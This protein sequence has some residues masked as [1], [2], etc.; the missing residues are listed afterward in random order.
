MRNVL[1]PALAALLVS[2]SLGRSAESW[3]GFRGPNAAGV[4]QTARPPFKFGPGETVL[5]KS[6]LPG[7]PS[8]PCIWGDRIFLT[9]FAAGK[10]EV[11]C[12]DRRD[13][14]QLWSR[15]VPTKKLEEFHQTEGSPAASTPAT[16][17]SRV[18]SYFGSCGLVCHDFAGKELWRHDLPPALT[19]GNFGSG[20][21]PIIAGELVLLNRD[22]TTG[23]SLLAVRLKDGQK[24][25]ETTRA[26]APTSYSTPVLHRHDG[27]EEVLVAGSLALKGYDPKT[28]LERWAVRGLPSY[29]CTTPVLG[30]GLIFFAGWSPGKADSPW[31][32]W[33]STLSKLDKNS[34]GVITLDEFTE[35]S[36]AAWFKSQDLN[37]NGQL[38][39]EDW[40]TIGGL[41]KRGNNVLLAV[42]PGGHGDVSTTHVAWK[43]ERG[44]PYVP[45]PLFYQGRIYLVKDGGML[46]SF[47]AKTGQP[48]Y[49]Q[50]RLKAQG[51]YYASPVAADGRIFLASLDGKMTVVKAGGVAPEIL[52]SADFKERITATP[53]LVGSHIFIRTATALH[54]FG[55]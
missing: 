4:S 24:A 15:A 11:R 52:H 8:S 48:F 41:M 36:D 28:G 2:L 33:E 7:S 5:W 38:D 46:S 27:A 32:S 26:D 54:A 6:E 17:G 21:S 14:K 53:A 20:T 50:E 34:D 9:T 12:L 3:P 39:R 19:A 55:P 49:T 1:F 29:T 43:F 23:S 42:K 31:P 30:D 16:E 44:L 10:L 40:D 25:W 22:Q 37:G 51:S 35:K 45:S 47:D 13:G 18:I